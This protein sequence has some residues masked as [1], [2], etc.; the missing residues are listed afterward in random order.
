MSNGITRRPCLRNLFEQL[1]QILK[2]V[3]FFVRARA[4]GDKEFLAET[5][6]FSLHRR[7]IKP[8]LY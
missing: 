6:C 7:G 8:V 4:I 5:Q 1:P 3:L 2:H